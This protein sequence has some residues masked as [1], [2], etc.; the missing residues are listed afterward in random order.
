[1]G[2]DNRLLM[3]LFGEVLPDD[4]SIPCGVQAFFSF[5]ASPYIAYCSGVGKPHPGTPPFEV[6]SK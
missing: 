5:S 4:D 3:I 2:I 1:M 6:N